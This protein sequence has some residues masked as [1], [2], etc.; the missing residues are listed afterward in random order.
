VDFEGNKDLLKNI[1]ESELQLTKELYKLITEDAKIGFEMT[2]HYYYNEN[3]LFYKMIN[4]K[5]LENEL[6]TI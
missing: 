3:L 4:L 5:N 1:L 6:K 2:N